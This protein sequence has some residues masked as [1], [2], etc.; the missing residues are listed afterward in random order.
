MNA[1]PTV[2]TLLVS[3]CRELTEELR[4]VG[5]VVSRV[6]GDVLIHVAEHT[7]DGR[8][9]HHGR[10]YLVSDFPETG[11]VLETGAPHAVSR[12][13]PDADRAEVTVLD[14]LGMAS[15]LMLSLTAGGA[16]WGLVEAYREDDAAFTADDE[17]RAA[18][19][20][21]RGATAL[22]AALSSGQPRAPEA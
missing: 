3:L 12:R 10:G 15:V 19:I 6:I 8:T 4:A 5:T 2:N 21:A 17:G 14:D 11:R 16:A 20:V 22:D 18:E 9:F 1:P 7:V 13:D